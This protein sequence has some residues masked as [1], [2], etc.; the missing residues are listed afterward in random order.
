MS[1]ALSHA[2]GVLQAHQPE[3]QERGVKHVAVFGSV[4]RGE[5]RPDSDVDILIELDPTAPMGVFEYSDLT[6]FI[7]D[8]FGQS[9]DVANRKTLRS[10][11]RDSILRD[12]VDA[13]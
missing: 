5:A 13:F 4:A 9:A 8:L 11:L 2:L 12:A 10:R 3:L 7:S 6:L 1:P